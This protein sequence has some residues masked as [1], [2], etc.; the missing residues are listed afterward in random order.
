MRVGADSAGV[1]EAEAHEGRKAEATERLAAC[2]PSE[3]RGETA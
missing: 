1:N 3:F 2:P